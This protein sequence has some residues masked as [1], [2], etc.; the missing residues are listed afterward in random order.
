MNKSSL[1][2]LL[3]ALWALLTIAV[4]LSAHANMTIS[5]LTGAVTSTEI[6]SYKTFM[7]GQPA[8][9][10][11]T[12]DNNMATGTAGVN[13]E[14]LGLM[15]EVSHDSQIL[16]M[17]IQYSDAFLSLRNDFTD[18]RVMWTGRVEPVWLTKPAG[19]TGGYAGSENNDIAG[20]IA[21]CAKLILQT[22][23][24]WNTTVAVGDPR[25][26]G[27]TYYQRAMTYITQMEYSEDQ[28]FTPNFINMSNYQI[29]APTSSAWTVFGESV[30]A[31]NRQMLFIN[32]WQRLS[33]CHAILG[34]DAYKLGLYDNIV[35]ASVTWF[36]SE[37]QNTTGGGQPAYVWQYA[38]SHS[39]G[40]EEMNGHAA[41]DMWGL[42]RTFMA[43][44][45]GMTQPL[46]RPF[47]E[48]LRYIIYQG[49]NTFA[50]WVNGDTSSTRNYIYGEWMGISAYDPCVFDIMANADI[51][52]GS[53]GTT[54]IYDAEIL[55][56][57]NARFL[58]I[59]PNNCDAAD[60]SIYSPW[61]ENIASGST[62]N[63][64]ATVEPLFGFGSGV[65]LTMSG[66]PSGVTASFSAGYNSTLTLSA[67]GSTASGVYAATITGTGG[68]ITRI[69]PVTLVVTNLGVPDFSVSATPSSQNI[70]IGGSTTYTVNVASLNGFGGNVALS[71]SGLPANAG[72]NFSP[73]TITGG[74]GASTL[75]ITTATNT[76]SGNYTL[77]VS[78]VSGSLT[79]SN[80]VTL[81]LN[82][83]SFS[84][85]PSSQTVTVGG[86]TNYTVN[87]GN[88]NG[89]GGT[90]NLTANGLPGG[91]T[92]SFNPT[93]I[94]SIGS[95]TMTISTTNTMPG[96]T[97]SFTVVG[98]DG[99]LQHGAS[100][101]LVVNA[102]GGGT[103]TEV[104]D[105][106]AG[107]TYGTGWTYG[108]S[109]N[110][111]DYQN[112]VHYASTAGSY[113]QYAFTGTGIEYITETYTDEGNVDVYIDGVLQATVNCNSS[114]RAAQVVVYSNTGLSAGSH[115][116]KVVKN[117]GTYM[118][119]DAFAYF[120]GPPQ[121][122][123]APTGLTATAASSSQINLSWTASS[124][125]TS[126][127]VKRATVSG[128]PYTPVATGVTGTTDN[129]TGL[130]AS[131][132]YYYVVS[133][134]NAA[135]E[136]ANSTEASATT[137]TPD[138]SITASP[139]SQTVTAG[140]NTTYT[141]TISA[142]NGFNSSVGLTVSG[143]PTGASGTFN[144]TPVTGS[145][146][147]TLTVTTTTNTPASTNTLTL[148]GTSGSLVHNTTVTLVVNAPSGGSLPT[149]WTD[150]DVG[151]PSPA[152]SASY[153][154]GV[155][156]VKGSGADIWGTSDQF[157]FAYQSDSGDCTIVARV[158]TV[159]N[160]QSSAKSGVMIRETQA[161]GSTYAGCYIT[162]ASGAKFEY[163]SSTGGSAVLGGSTA[164]ITA[165]YWVKMARSGSTFTASIS[166]DGTT[167]TSL[168]SATITM[169]AGIS[170]GL[171]VCSHLAGT[172]CTATLDNVSVTTP[173]PDFSITASPASQTVTA[174]NNTTYTAT[175]SALNGFNSSVGLTVSGLPTGASGTFNPTSVTGSGTSTLTVTTTTN[176]PAGTNTLTLTGTSGNLVHTATVTLVVNAAGG[177]DSNI[178]PNGT[179][180]G[181][182]ANT[183]ATANSNRT[184]LP[185]LNDNN[186]TADVDIDAAGDAVNA[187]EGAGVVWSSAKTISSANFI[188]GTVTSGG[189]GFLT[190]NCELQ[191]STDGS[192]WV[193]SGWTISPAYPNSSA[194]S[195]QTYTFSGTAVSGKLGARVV[196]QVRTTDTSYH[197]IVK[198]VRFIGH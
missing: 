183:S 26:Y 98:T 88:I 168:G 111:G 126:Y 1:Q 51:T 101:T 164:G 95:S 46:L 92:A 145:G 45:Y 85:T 74:S 33:E 63:Y 75:S 172:L 17:M 186:L 96:G 57:K 13:A 89:F 90:V 72:G 112:D 64:P 62:T 27:T 130:A 76:P 30:N 162:S 161:A 175:V 121:P 157:N 125:A 185:G 171:P 122:P 194:A 6:S 23:S 141:A 173:A 150:A 196:G 50:E 189:D 81:V 31:W 193:N 104:N 136:S 152:G 21:Y 198:E 58:G 120:S 142:L 19:S 144:P 52:Q 135:G 5:S 42:S 195:G 16:D 84:V 60:Y 93:S 151:S 53:Q 127:N 73:S 138:F 181:W 165:P 15:Y 91:A 158:A 169:A 35:K 38:P 44:K 155:F 109:R 3:S 56:V 106:D 192:T 132:A 40:N 100:A 10:A 177:S 20:H 41:Y 170:I 180:Y 174:G 153:S 82:D 94:N 154:S 103:W 80:T 32:A 49:N 134:V 29:T 131:T 115:T 163:R 146:S 156:T 87:V 166:P 78:G 128:G 124:G 34:D 2:S 102:S 68:G 105:T 25:G 18:R 107:I 65:T 148:T 14:S 114:T 28:Y 139:A 66:L 37:W 179:A 129:D 22:P 191:F 187:W 54:P 176:T 140:N 143:L 149:G 86:N 110:L 97:N 197:W 61:V 36:Q 43:A 182:N 69:V 67:S 99:S 147:S 108:P 71:V 133:A 123:L 11:N 137:L 77:T 160:T 70:T 117:S 113:A 59:F 39:G 116:I 159:Q 79:H 119:V 118:L 7:Q 167:W 184:A 55:W 178:A 190:A 24:L 9:T 8:P 4:P 12:Y 48:T 188:N 47:A 83:F